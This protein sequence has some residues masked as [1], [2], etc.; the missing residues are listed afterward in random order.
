MNTRRLPLNL[1][2]D[3]RSI[4]GLG[5]GAAVTACS[6]KPA[7]LD[8][9]VAALPD[10]AASFDA[11]ALDASTGLDALADDAAAA[12]ALPLDAEALDAEA[13]DVGLPDSGE[14]CEV[15]PPDAMGPFYRAG[16]PSR[17]ELVDAREP[18]DRLEITGVVVGPDC[19]TPV[20][21]ALLDVWQADAAGRYDT[22]SANYRLRAVMMADAQGAF[23]FASVRP[24]NY[25]DAGGMRPAHVHF[26]VSHPD[27]RSVT[28]QLY[29][30][31][32][33][34]LAPVDSCRSCQSDEESLIIELREEQRAG[35][36]WFVGR[37]RIV[38][39]QRR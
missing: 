4:L 29:F 36:R 8:A 13:L 23:G 31:G 34:F 24:G 22:T 19:S 27:H 30:R 7:G 10:A 35:V 26:T 37:F 25:P 28:T 6:S 17:V 1:A 2:L 33:P 32:D 39:A 38:L 18:G 12:D 11:G 3:R 14:A 20:S 16:A 15:T 5:L 21:G 9:G